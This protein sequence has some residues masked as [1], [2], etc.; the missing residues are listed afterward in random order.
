MIKIRTAIY[1][2][3][4]LFL[5]YLV[6][7]AHLIEPLTAQSTFAAASY[8]LIYAFHMP[9]FALLSG[10]FSA[11][12]GLKQ[13]KRLLLWYAPL[14]TAAVLFGK[15]T[16]LTP[17]W[18]LWYLL[19]SASWILMARI[20]AHFTERKWLIF[21]LAVFVG[22]AAGFV[23][24]VDRTLSLSRTL[25]F[26]PYFWLGKCLQPN[27]NWSKYRLPCFIFALISVGAVFV[28][29]FE[30]PFLYQAASY[31][32]LLS[33]AMMRFACYILGTVL[34]VCAL[35]MMPIHRLSCSKAGTD[36]F[37]LYIFHAPIVLFLQRYR[38][39][40]A[41]CLLV[42]ALIVWGFY[43]LQQHGRCFCGI[44]ERGK[45]WPDFK[46]SMKNMPDRSTDSS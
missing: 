13:A 17:Y 43:K 38:I 2:N 16:I 34:T 5:I 37:Y 19:S 42:A 7:Y 30:T 21:A 44:E 18:H 10:M 14:Q 1:C 45:Q 41:L 35:S 22:C 9:S 4:K 27:I 3:F 29:P 28:L 24:F 26:F 40:P 15:T 46:Q 8:R 31:E 12:H 20:C 11:K 23:P 25:V 6:V 36:T 32:N 39:V 33:G